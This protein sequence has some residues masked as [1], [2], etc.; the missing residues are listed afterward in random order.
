MSFKGMFENGKLNGEGKFFIE[1]TGGTYSV[2]SIWNFG[3]PELKCNKYVLTVVSPVKEEEDPKAK[4]DAKKGAIE[5]EPEGNNEIKVVIDVT[6][7]NEEARI[8]SL[9]L[10]VI[11]Q[12]EAYKNPELDESA[13]TPEDAKKKKK[14]KDELEEPSMIMPDPVTLEKESGRLFEFEL[15]RSEIVKP[16]VTED[17]TNADGLNTARSKDEQ[18]NPEAS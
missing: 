8:F 9:D 16:D 15:G 4:K 13:V 10:V 14:G 3:V 11:F 12:G 17:P 6:N 18:T 5:E 2:E 1:G 7:P